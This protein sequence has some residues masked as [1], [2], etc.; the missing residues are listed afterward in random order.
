MEYKVTWLYVIVKNAGFVSERFLMNFILLFHYNWAATLQNQQ[1]ECASSED[2]SLSA[3]RNLGSLATH[4]AHSEDSDQTGRVPR[5]IWDFAGRTLIVL[6]LSCRGS[7]YHYFRM[8]YSPAPESHYI[9]FLGP[10]K[11]S[12]LK[13]E[14]QRNKWKHAFKFNTDE[15]CK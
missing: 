14:Q 9:Y 11:K 6:V 8:M 2:S 5:L 13:T 4:W 10:R 1:S 7:Y 15:I 3:W 12:K